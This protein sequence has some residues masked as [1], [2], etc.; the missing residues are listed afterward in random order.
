MWNY[1]IHHIN[2]S[3]SKSKDVLFCFLF[4]FF[5][6]SGSIGVNLCASSIFDNLTTENIHSCEQQKVCPE[7]SMRVQEL[8]K[9]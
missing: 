4:F 9:S 5:F 1:R 6:I 7:K 8:V 2:M 3:Y